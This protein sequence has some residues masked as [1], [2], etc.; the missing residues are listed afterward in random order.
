VDDLVPDV[1]RRPIFGQR[2]FDDLDRPVDTG[3]KTP[4]RS[5]QNSKGGFVG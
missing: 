1:N 3:T 2:P 5:Q 4:W